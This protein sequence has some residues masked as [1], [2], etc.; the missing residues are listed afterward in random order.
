MGH[1]P[2]IVIATVRGAVGKELA[3]LG[4]AYGA[5]VS[6]IDDAG[7]PAI[8][9]PWVKGPRWV[10]S[11]GEMEGEAPDALVIVDVADPDVWIAEGKKRSIKRIVVVGPGGPTDGIIQAR[12]GRVVDGPLDPEAPTADDDMIRVERLA[13]ALLR[14]AIDDPIPAQ[15]DHAALCDLGDAVFWQ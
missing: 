3:R 14:A 4:V 12:P 5:E 13:M 15:L 2:T 6:V 1:I 8:D 10:A 7:P 9:E 11:F